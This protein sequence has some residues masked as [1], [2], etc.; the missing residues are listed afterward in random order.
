MQGLYSLMEVLITNL[1]KKCIDSYYNACAFNYIYHLKRKTYIVSIVS[2]DKDNFI[3]IFGL[4]HLKDI[5]NFTTKKKKEK[6]KITKKIY[7]E[8][9]TYD[10]ISKSSFFA[11]PINGTSKKYKSYTIEDRIN[12]LAKYDAIL[13][14]SYTGKLYK[15]DKYKC[16][17]Y[18]GTK[19]DADFVLVIPKDEITK[20]NYYFFLYCQEK[21]DCDS[22]IQKLCV[23]TAFIDS[24]LECGLE[25]PYSIQKLEKE[26]VVTKSTITLWEMHS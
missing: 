18:K 8:K 12:G 2:S 5:Y 1:L 3:H 22:N 17:K 16:Q 13:D 10:D 23:Q 19:I 11:T 26:N 6:N 9:I 21:Q 25:S 7:E 20:E 4:H 15:W 14:V 24:G